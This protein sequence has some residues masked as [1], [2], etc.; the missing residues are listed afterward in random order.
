MLVPEQLADRMWMTSS[1]A[2]ARLGVKQSTVYAYVSRGLIRRTTHG[3]RTMLRRDDV[4]KLA[5]RGRK[6]SGGAAKPKLLETAVSAI[7]DDRLSYRGRD[8][9]ALS[10]TWAF[11]QVAVWLWTGREV[12]PPDVAPWRGV[13][14]SLPRQPVARLPLDRMITALCLA[15]PS[16]AGGPPHDVEDL[17]ISLIS[18]LVD[19][20]GGSVRPMI[21]ERITENLLADASP[22]TV[23]LVDAALIL[24]SEHGL[25]APTV[26]ARTVASIR[27]DLRLGTV[28][29]LC[30]MRGTQPGS[31]S[32][33][34][35][36]LLR[37]LHSMDDDSARGTLR[38]LHAN[39]PT[40]PGTGHP[41][42]RAED[43]R[44]AEILSRLRQ[45]ELHPL[46]LAKIGMFAQE[47]A[48]AGRFVN[49]DFAFGALSYATQMRRGASEAIFG[50]ART[51]GWIAHMTEEL[52]SENNFRLD[53]IYV[54]PE[55]S[56][57]CF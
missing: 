26:N 32:L 22:A 21:A 19:S 11:E 42:Y 46:R 48:R 4:E 31:A 36:D 10:R 20:L 38:W 1:E 41:I 3:R 50:I 43:P 35:E 52:I 29:G 39:T 8:A 49:L 45:S 12:P 47:A 55:P 56:A 51:A 24:A 14:S 18:C 25:A 16:M 54:G 28:A 17:G 6:A 34:V 7:A 13:R 40:V 57:S 15:A 5:A 30:A 53:V 37:R 9:V 2:A 27:G 44:A 33:R 23:G